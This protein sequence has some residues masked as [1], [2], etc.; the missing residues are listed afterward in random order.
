[1]RLFA[2][3][4]LAA[5]ALAIGLTNAQV[6]AASQADSDFVKEAASGGKMEVKLG[7]YAAKNAADAQVN[8]F[9]ERMVADHGKANAE[10]TKICERAAIE[11][12]KDTATKHDAM[13]D[14]LTALKG[15]EFDRAYMD[16]MVEDHEHD[17]EAFREAAKSAENAE[18]KQFAQKTLPTLE[19]HLKMAK[20][21]DARLE[22]GAAAK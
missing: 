9:G 19:E 5:A 21:I 20:E 4:L 10:L 11:V 7:Q 12:P 22:K 17:V 6:A 16:A 15:A 14:R 8:R 1:M 13:V 18:V 3:G 2:N